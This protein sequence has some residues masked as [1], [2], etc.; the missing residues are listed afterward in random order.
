VRE[1]ARRSQLLSWIVLAL[2]AGDMVLIPVGIGDTGTLTAV[3]IFFLS[4]VVSIFFNRRGLVTTA[5]IVPVVL[6]WLAVMISLIS[7][8]GGLALDALPGYDLLCAAVVLAASVVRPGAAF[9]VAAINIGL[10]LGDFFAQQHAPDL[11]ADIISYGDP[12][13]GVITLLARPVALE[14]MLAVIAYLWVRGANTAIRRADRAEELAQL[15]TAV[16]E[17][18]QQLDVGIAEILRVHTAAANGDFHAR[19]QMLGRDHALWNLAMSLNNLLGRV[20]RAGMAEH[21]LA[22]TE[23]ELARLE[24]AVEDIAARRRAIWPQPSGTVADRIIVQLGRLLGQGT[25]QQIPGS[26]PF[27]APQPN[28][29]PQARG[30]A[31]PWDTRRSPQTSAGGGF[32]PPPSL[33]PMEHRQTPGTPGMPETGQLRDPFAPPDGLPPFPGEARE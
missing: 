17:Q 25:R 22:R 10:I 30:M 9:V 26:P 3:V 14:I 1:K 32:V 2:L 31:D 12:T 20:Q 15:Q 27:G 7:E 8:P 29:Q 21:Q 33:H 13:V 18:K 16:V 5:G 24:G 11:R 23:Q 6:I 4:L 19:V 28:S